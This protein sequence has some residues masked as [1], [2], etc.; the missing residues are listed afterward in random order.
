M[1]NTDKDINLIMKYFKVSREEALTAPD[2]L[3]DLLG[4]KYDETT[5]T[6]S[7]DPITK[8]SKADMQY[9]LEVAKRYELSH[10]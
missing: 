9:A 3:L 2:H 1:P 4:I 7:R 6:F 8:L 5:D 10:D